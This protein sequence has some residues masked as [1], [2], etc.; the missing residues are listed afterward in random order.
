MK[1]SFSTE[2]VDLHHQA[3]NRNKRESAYYWEEL[4]TWI[5]ASGF[6]QIEIPYEPKWD[7]GGRSGIPLTMRSITTKYGTVSNYLSL[8]KRK[9]ISS[10]RSVHFDP[11]IFCGDNMDMYFGA[12]EHFAFEAI[13]FAKEAGAQ[14]FT[15]SATPHIAAIHSLK[16]ENSTLE[17]LD[18]TFLEKTAALISKLS[19]EAKALRIKLCLKNE[20]WGL[21]RGDC[22]VSFVESLPPNVLLDVDTAHLY[23]SGINICD[24]INANS[25]R[26]GAV[27][28]T[29]TAFYDDQDAYL[30]ALPEFPAKR[31][32]KVFLDIGCGKIDF[33]QIYRMLID[34]NYDEDIIYNC[35]NS[36]DVSRSLLRT[37]YYI[38]CNLKHLERS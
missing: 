28:F 38:N 19:I 6:T 25:S 36:Y 13:A 11:S 31:A 23:I 15:L 7:F 16:I 10:I 14:I 22:I 32:T 17:E 35:R 8:L 30:Q 29:D 20:Y 2:V 12:F 18:K 27:H 33:P 34:Q 1:T 24:Y 37:R 4:Y 5:A 3:P 26:I 9:G 21:L